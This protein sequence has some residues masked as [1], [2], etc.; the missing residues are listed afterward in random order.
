MI[1]PIAVKNIPAVQHC[2]FNAQLLVAGWL[3]YSRLA[4]LHAKANGRGWP[5]GLTRRMVWE[6]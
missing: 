2:E 4:A 3:T 6:V 1:C 5:G